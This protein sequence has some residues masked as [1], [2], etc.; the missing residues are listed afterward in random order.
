MYFI[1]KQSAEILQD[2]DYNEQPLST[3]RLWSAGEP[4]GHGQQCHH[5]L[6]PSPCQKLWEQGP[7]I[8]ALK[9]LRGILVRPGLWKPLH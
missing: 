3:G 5:Y 8:S 4:A 1:F 2:K 6:S 7:E 9:A